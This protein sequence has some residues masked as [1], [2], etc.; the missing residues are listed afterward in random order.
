MHRVLVVANQTLGGMELLKEIE[1]RAA[2][3]LCEFFVLVPATPPADLHSAPIAIRSDGA[4][5]SV[6]SDA[7]ANDGA[8]AA[9]A[10]L[11][12]ELDRLHAAGFKASGEI[13]D[14]DPV[15]AVDAAVTAG[16]FDEIIIATLPAGP[17]RWLRQDL[18]HRVQRHVSL[19][20]THV[21]AAI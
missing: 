16:T 17:S 12:R 14:P 8:A 3:Q 7:G 15:K 5:S 6:F 4:S 21:V 19:P 10:R 11:N 1:R 2:S 9:E 13:G 20:V 18:V